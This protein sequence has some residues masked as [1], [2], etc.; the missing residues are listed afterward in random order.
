[1]FYIYAGK[2]EALKAMGHTMRALI[3][4]DEEDIC[5]LLASYLRKQHIDVTYS[6]TLEEGLKKIKEFHPTI[7]FLDNNLPDGLGID[8]IEKIRKIKQD[9]KIIV[10]S[11]LTNLREKA[12]NS[13]ADGFIDKPISFAT[14]QKALNR[15]TGN[16]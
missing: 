4:D 9:L 8:A 1:M 16:Y 5:V 10:I 3:I 14:I 15:K 7:L 2:Q 12:M 6:F 13:T 11:A